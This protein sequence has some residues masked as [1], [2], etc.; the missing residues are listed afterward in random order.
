MAVGKLEDGT[1]VGGVVVGIEVG[2][3]SSVGAFVGINVGIAV[4]SK[5]RTTII[6]VINL[7]STSDHFLKSINRRELSC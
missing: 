3:I 7:L 1:D 6:A 5:S 4:V 2:N